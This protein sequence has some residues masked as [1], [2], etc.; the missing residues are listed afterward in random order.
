MEAARLKRHK[1]VDERRAAR[2][3]ERRLAISGADS[4]DAV[5]LTSSM[6]SALIAEI[7]ADAREAEQAQLEQLERARDES[8]LEELLAFQ[9]LSLKDTFVPCPA[10]TDGALIL[11]SSVLTCKCG[12]RVNLGCGEGYTLA[13]VRESLAQTFEKHAQ[14]TAK[15]IFRA[16]NPADKLPFLGVELPHQHRQQQ[17]QFLMASCASCGCE[18]IVV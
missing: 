1:T 16:E 11:Q 3:L 2:V 10:C 14:C 15:L 4:Y 18:D 7:D 9:H 13:N 6:L 12:L 17:Q 5:S 8:D